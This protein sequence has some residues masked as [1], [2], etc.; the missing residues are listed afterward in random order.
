MNARILGT[1][2]G[3]PPRVVTN[4]ELVKQVGVTNEW[5]VQRTGIQTRRFVDEGVGPSDLGL[6]AS[7][8][9]IR[10]A[11]LKAEDIDL[12]I[13]ATFTPD[14]QA[15]GSSWLLQDKLG[16]QGVATLDVRAQCAG[17]LWAMSIA[18][19][20]IVSGKHRHVLVV[21]AEVQSTI[22]DYSEKGRGVAILMGD[23]AG[24]VVMGPC[25][26]KKRGVLD[27]FLHSDGSN[28]KSLWMQAPMTVRK[29]YLT[30]AMIDEGMHF[31]QMDGRRVFS[32]AL[33]R[34]PETIMEA[35]QKGGYTQK[36]VNLLIPHQANLR[37]IEAVAQKL[38]FPMEKVYTNIQRYGNT[39]G[40]S[41]PIALHEA[42][43]EGRVREGDL[44]VFA[45]F[46]GGFAWGSALLRW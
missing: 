4:E 37:I 14:Y 5:I 6:E 2:I 46:G 42:L 25:E 23:G 16:L 11:G 29:P 12:I 21:A 22:L 44:L 31:L 43:N 1:G 10:N 20:F 3:L 13:F 9:A 15:P 27:V 40:A 24:A 8:Q 33:L 34:F 28:F 18:N 19:Q 30:H 35:M 45:A 32:T 7:H 36:D 41:I 26:D 17:F 39:S 38:E